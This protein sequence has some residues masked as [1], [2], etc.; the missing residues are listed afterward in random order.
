MKKLIKLFALLVVML[1]VS[2]PAMCQGIETIDFSN[3]KSYFANLV[4]DTG[5]FVALAIAIA[6]TINNVFKITNTIVK[7]I[8]SWVVIILLAFIG[9]LLHWGMFA[10]STW[11][12]TLAYACAAIFIANYG[13]DFPTVRKVLDLVLT[14]ITFIISKFKK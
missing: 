12:E 2:I 1:I 6:F 10:T 14:F 4:S 9:M 5:G 13:Y 8:V 11:Y 3:I 7:Q